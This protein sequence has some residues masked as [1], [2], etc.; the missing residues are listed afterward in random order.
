MRRAPG[1]KRPTP[2]P[3]ARTST[4]KKKKIPAK[5]IVIRSPI[6]SSSS[7][8]SSESSL[9]K[10]VP[11]QYGLGHSIPTSE[12]LALPVEEEA[13]VDQPDGCE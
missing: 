13:S 2:F 9:P 11:G 4:D 12:R 10:R 5:G 3:P 6:P 8:S 1:E 7:A